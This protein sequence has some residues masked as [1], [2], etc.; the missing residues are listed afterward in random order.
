MVYDAT[1]RVMVAKVLLILRDHEVSKTKRFLFIRANSIEFSIARMCKVPEV[2]TS[3]YYAWINKPKAKQ[4][5]ENESLLED[6]KTVFY[7]SKKVFDSRKVKRK[8]KKQYLIL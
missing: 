5:I 7:K 4:D 3:D 6:I 8:R 2:S 1:I